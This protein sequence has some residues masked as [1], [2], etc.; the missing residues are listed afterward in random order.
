MNVGLIAHDA[1]KMLMQNL[2]IAYPGYFEAAYAVRHSHHGK[3][4]RGS[5]KLND[6]QASGGTFRRHASDRS[7]DRKQ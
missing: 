4:D 6:S 2:C 3:G 5:D 1:K 7:A